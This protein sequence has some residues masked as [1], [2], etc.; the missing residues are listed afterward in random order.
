MGT[1]ITYLLEA[2]ELVDELE[3]RTKVLAD[4]YYWDQVAMIRQALQEAQY[5]LGYTRQ[6]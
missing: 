2:Q 4:T 6:P 3:Q 1:V 5:K